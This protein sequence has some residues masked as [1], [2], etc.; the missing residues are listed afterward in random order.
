MVTAQDAVNAPSWVVTVTVVLPSAR[1]FAAPLWALMLTSS[2]LAVLQLTVWLSALYGWTLAAR[3]K[4]SPARTEISV[5]LMVTPLTGMVFLVVSGAA[6]GVQVQLRAMPMTQQDK[7][8][9]AF[10]Y[11]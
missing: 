1:A 11:N 8:F 9:K 3:V 7:N 5:R 6:L 2:G 4:A 10:M